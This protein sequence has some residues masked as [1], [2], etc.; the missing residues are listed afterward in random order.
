MS[1]LEDHN[2]WNVTASYSH[3]GTQDAESMV[4]FSE[5]HRAI[6]RLP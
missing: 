3:S 2:L 1:T 5:E 4:N 6:V